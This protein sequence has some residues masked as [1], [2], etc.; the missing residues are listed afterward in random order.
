MAM[1]DKIH[2]LE[3]GGFETKSFRETM[4]K[5]DEESY[6][7]QFKS[8]CQCLESKPIMKCSENGVSAYCGKCSKGF[9]T[10]G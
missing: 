6:F 4:R 3:N 2:K 5:I 7:R 9:K 10:N 1:N 8:E